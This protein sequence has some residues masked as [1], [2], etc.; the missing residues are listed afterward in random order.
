MTSNEILIVGA[1]F[2]HYIDQNYD[3]NLKIPDTDRKN[4]KHPIGD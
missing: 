1:D 3:K 4:D 2:I